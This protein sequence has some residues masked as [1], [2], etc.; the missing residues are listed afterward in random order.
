MGKIIPLTF[1]YV[2]IGSKLA[3]LRFFA[4]AADS[5]A[6]YEAFEI[7]NYRISEESNFRIFKFSKFRIFQ[8]SNFSN[9]D[10]F[11]SDFEVLG[12]PTI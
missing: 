4:A 10:F 5:T 12:R 8:E 9:F 7:S 1:I 2:K 6:D 11:S 3:E